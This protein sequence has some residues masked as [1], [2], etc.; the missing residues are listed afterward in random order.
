MKKILMFSVFILSACSPKY[1]YM[2]RK[3]KDSFTQ[4]YDNAEIETN[5]K[6]KLNGYYI[7]KTSTDKVVVNSILFFKDGSLAFNVHVGGLFYDEDRLHKY[8]T[9]GTYSVK[10]DTLTIQTVNHNFFSSFCLEGKYLILNDTT[11]KE[12]Y[13]KDLVSKTVQLND[14]T[15]NPYYIL[16]LNFKKKE[17]KPD[18]LCWLKEKRWFWCNKEQYK[19]WKK[20]QKKKYKNK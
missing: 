7:G 13:T 12:L 5:G 6:I 8:G 3:V 16:P 20:E 1:L 2:P 10:D 18:S 19:K 11:L 14:I 17:N 4:C 15:K 9:W